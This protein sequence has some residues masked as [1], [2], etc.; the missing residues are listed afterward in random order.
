MKNLIATTVIAATLAAP[1]FAGSGKD[2]LAALAGVSAENYSISEL[3]RL[4]AAQKDGDATTSSFIKAKANGNVISTQNSVSAGQAQLAASVGVEPGSLTQA[5]M[6]RLDQALREGDATKANYII[7]QA[8]GDSISSQSGISAGDAQ[9]AAL[10]G[11]EP[12]S[13]T[14]AQM[15]RLDQAQ[16]EGDASTAN[17]ILSQ[18]R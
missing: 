13:L 7:D 4:D 1:A 5:E 14:R 11:V 8:N 3:V 9:L 16:K 17:F 10:V 2:Q 15:I 6:I 18:A 12:G